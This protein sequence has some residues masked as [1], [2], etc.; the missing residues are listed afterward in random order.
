VWRDLQNELSDRNFVVVAVALDSDTNAVRHWFEAANSPAYPVLID[1]SHRL[2]DLYNLV[3]VP[4]ATWIDEDR[5]IVRPPETAGYYDS[6]RFM[7]P[8]T[9]TVPEA[10]AAK[11]GQARQI[12]LD[13]IRDWVEHGAA[14]RFVM[15]PQDARAKMPEANANIA[16]AHVLFRL[17]RHLLDAGRTTESEDLM[18]EASRLHPDSW[19]IWRQSAEKN[20]A[21]LA[22]TPA[23]LD[24]VRA[25]GEKHYYPPPDIEGMP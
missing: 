20:E 2:A 4:Q 3:N 23:F 1:R 7:D 11:V 19:A 13:A 14:S 22:T 24:R 21:G 8:E 17:A 5:R 15:S 16:Q 6:I 9:M 12:Y 18:A 10:E 25:L